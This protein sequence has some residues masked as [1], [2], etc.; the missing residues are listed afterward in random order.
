M[1]SAPTSSRRRPR[2]GRAS[3][4]RPAQ[5]KGAAPAAPFFFGNAA[6]QR[7]SE[8]ASGPHLEINSFRRMSDSRAAPWRSRP[9]TKW[10]RRVRTQSV[11]T[12]CLGRK[13]AVAL[14]IRTP[15]TLPL[16]GKIVLRTCA[17]SVMPCSL[18]IPRCM[19]APSEPPVWK[20]PDPPGPHPALVY[21]HQCVRFATCRSGL[22]PCES[23]T[24]GSRVPVCPLS[25]TFE[26]SLGTVGPALRSR[27]DFMV[28][29]I[30]Q[31]C[32]GVAVGTRGRFGDPIL[33]V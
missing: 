14:L 17:E 29:A 32:H 20:A 31:R 12:K 13:R 24:L 16:F 21:S 8:S 33:L 11:T 25:V 7:T 22:R 15:H 3:A 9:P 2:A 10:N 1:P 18:A 4:P 5:S 28:Q 27:P 23:G 30:T 19:T 26:S 6:Q